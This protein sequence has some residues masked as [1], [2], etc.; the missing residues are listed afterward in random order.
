MMQVILKFYLNRGTVEE[1]RDGT[2]ILN[3]GKGF[4]DSVDNQS[5]SL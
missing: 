4:R 1:S 2:W 3:Y 5:N